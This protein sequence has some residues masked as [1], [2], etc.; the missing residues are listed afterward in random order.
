M[1]GQVSS[2]QLRLGGSAQG[3]TG[4]CIAVER[5]GERNVVTAVLASDDPCGGTGSTRLLRFGWGGWDGSCRV[6]TWD[7]TVSEGREVTLYHRGLIRLR[8]EEKS[9]H[10]STGCN[11]VAGC[12][13]VIQLC[14]CKWLDGRGRGRGRCSGRRLGRGFGGA[15]CIADLPNVRHHLEA[16]LLAEW[17]GSGHKAWDRLSAGFGLEVGEGGLRVL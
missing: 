7:V 9:Q 15:G 17:V 12:C 13:T 8:R 11:H 14:P 16:I 2:L 6:G 4:R 3:S 1:R 10:R 5:L